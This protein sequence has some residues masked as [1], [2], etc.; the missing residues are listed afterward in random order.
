MSKPILSIVDQ[1][2]Y[3]DN[4]LGSTHS[5]EEA[6]DLIDG[7]RQLLDTGGF[8]IRQ[9]A[10][11]VPVIIEHLPSDVRNESSELWLSHSS[12]DLQEPTLGLGWD[13]LCDSLKYKH[14]QVER[15]EPTLS[16]VYKVLACQYDPLGYIVPFTTRT[17]ILVQ[18]LW[19]EQIGCDNPIQPQSLHDDGL[20]GNASFPTSSRW[21]SLDAMHQHLQ[22]PQ[23]PTESCTS[24]ATPRKEP[25]GLSLTCPRQ[26]PCCTKKPAVHATTGDECSTHWCS[27]SQRASK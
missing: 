11:N 18:D 13:C 22:T 6:K 19:K 14:R 4:C 15:T 7:L 17:K 24:S 25:T 27:I 16:N 10:S 1:S 21:R 8:E 20:P 23:H 26:V 9:W 5:K 2:F 3:V 12:T